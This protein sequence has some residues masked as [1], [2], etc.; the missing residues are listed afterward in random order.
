MIF[1]KVLIGLP[2]IVLLLVFAFVNNNMVELSLWPTDIEVTI[3][4]SVLVVLLYVVGYIMG[5]FFTWLSYAP[6]RKALR[7]Q[8]KQ[9]LKMTK[10]QAK[11]NKE[12]EDLRGNID[13]LKS[14]VTPKD[15]DK[16]P[17][18][19]WKNIFKSKADKN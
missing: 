16:K 5:W 3:S 11:L 2:I 13:V 6:I 17:F 10:E 14:V 12:V 1:F 19:A 18:F 9:N 7:S 15:E 4:Q 8:K